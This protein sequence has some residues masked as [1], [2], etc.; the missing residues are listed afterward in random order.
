MVLI[1]F[2][3]S[4]LMAAAI[5]APMH[6]AIADHLGNSTVAENLVRGFDSSW[7]TE[8]QI[9]QATFVKSFSIAI[10]Y[11]AI[12]FLALST[13]LSAG[14]FELFVRPEGSPLAVFGRGIGKY[15]FRFAR[16][17]VIASVFYFLAFWFWN[18]PVSNLLNYAFADSAVERVHF[19]LEWLRWA[20]LLATVGFVNV[21]VEY[22]KADIVI[23]EHDSALAAIGHAAGFVL[24]NFKRVLAIYL[25][26]ALMTAVT[27]ALYSTFARFFPQ[28]SAITVTIWFLVAQILIWLRWYF[29]IASWG[30]AVA[31]YRAGRAQ[32]PVV[33][34]EEVPA[35]A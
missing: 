24:R 10:V 6:A 17:I 12:L 28:A 5:A 4:I 25:A 13:M 30:A 29:R 19:Y 14:A 34:V 33:R 27:I 22:A 26:L 31:F 2:A 23:D 35:Q 21:V 16:L 8:F 11:G 3:A 32:A 7:L 9:S 15:F 18:G 1:F 20:L